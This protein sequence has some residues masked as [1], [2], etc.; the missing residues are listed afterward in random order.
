MGCTLSQVGVRRLCTPDVVYIEKANV[1]HVYMAKRTR[2]PGIIARKNRGPKPLAWRK[3]RISEHR[4]AIKGLTHQKMADALAE[5]GIELS[6]VS[7]G[8]IERGE[9]RPFGDVLEAMAAILK[10][11]VDSM[12]NY[13]PDEAKAI[14]EFKELGP[15]QRERAIRTFRASQEDE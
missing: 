13:P 15:K 12:L 1:H 2:S 6:R 11:D 4:E 5:R 8:R 7:V 3:S 14:A 10:T 9:Q